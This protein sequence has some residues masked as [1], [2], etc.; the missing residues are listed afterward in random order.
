[1]RTTRFGLGRLEH[2]ACHRAAA[3]RLREDVDGSP[4]L[5]HDLALK[6]NRARLARLSGQ[7]GTAL[8]S[9]ER[10]DEEISVIQ[11]EIEALELSLMQVVETSTATN[12]P[13]ESCD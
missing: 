4:Q 8:R 7:R 12:C 10:L 3:A 6:R 5:R 9:L 2:Q 13:L 11:L 1:M